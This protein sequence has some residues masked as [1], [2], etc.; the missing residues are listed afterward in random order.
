MKIRVMVIFAIMATLA[1]T[2]I[3]SPD[4]PVPDRPKIGLCLAGGGARGGA[5]I[6]VLKVLEELRIP[7]DYI[8][9]T[10]IGSVIG[11]LYAAGMTPAEMDSALTGI[12]W[13]DLFDDAPERTHINF[14]RKEEDR[15]PYFGFEM[16]LGSHGLKMPAGFVAGTKLLFMLR[17]LTLSTVNIHN[18]DDL[19]IPFRAAATSLNS[20]EVAVIDHG[21]LA[22]AMRASMAIPGVFTPH[23][24]DG[25]TLVDG[26]ILRNL[27]YEEVKAMG[28]DI[29]IIVDVGTPLGQLD[30]D[31]SV[32]GI[33]NQAVG[34]GT[35]ANARV[36]RNLAGEQDILL[37][38]ELEGIGAESF[39]RMAEAAEQGRT[40]AD[41][42]R[43]QLRVLSLPEAEYQAWWADVQSR[44]RE[45]AVRI[46]SIRAGSPGRIDQRRVRMQVRS[47]LDMPLDMDVLSD[48]LERVFRLGDFELVDYTLEPSSD[49]S[50]H[51]LVVQTTDKRWGPNYLRLG[52]TLEGHVDGQTRF[53]LLVYH[54]MAEINRLGAEWRNQFSLGSPLALDSEFYQPLSLNGRFFVAPRISGALSERERWFDGDLSELVSEKQY[55]GRLDLGLNFSHWG[56]LRLGV[57][58]GHYWGEVESTTFK[59]DEALG[60]WRGRLAFDQ[61]DDW[62]F[63]RR[64]WAVNVTGRVSRDA[65][66]ATIEYERL[67]LQAR[68]A[69][70]TGAVTFLGRLEGGTS[71]QSKLPFNDRFELGGFSRL[72]GLERGRLFGDDLVAAA[73]GVQ[74]QIAQLSPALGGNVYFGLFGEAGQT[75]QYEDT[76]TL[77]DLIPGFTSYLG[78]ETLLGPVYMGYGYAEGGHQSLY[79]FLGRGPF[80]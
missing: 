2:T 71:F 55:R 29:V 48:D 11:G 47:K 60:G 15:L 68:G 74:F 72:S 61:L 75:W 35:N 18:F 63:P 58:R 37:V 34:V 9:G 73:A 77:S 39:E 65:L 32:T 12:D 76:P 3:A 4:Q 23:V 38:P 30:P 52:L 16:G 33:L 40:V 42:H 78:A 25:E 44:R 7:V 41:Q 67:A 43:D 1:Q 24:I 64:G 79:V 69:V 66:G 10:S 26:M 5:H 21:T 70:S 19:P 62:N 13:V 27:P 56:E 50:A 59:E 45:E 53:A 31:P 22:D 80:F 20:G 49:A 46:G 36:S 28:A 8:T 54:R 6:G 51:D 14:R 57:Y 17:E